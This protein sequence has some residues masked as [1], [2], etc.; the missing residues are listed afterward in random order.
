MIPNVSK[1]TC[2]QNMFEGLYVKHN[3]TIL[4]VRESLPIVPRP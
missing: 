2:P 4:A 3:G 1:W